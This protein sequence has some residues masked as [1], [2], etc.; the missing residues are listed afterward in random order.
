MKALD[1]F[2]QKN[3]LY[4][5]LLFLL[6]AALALVP[7]ALGQAYF[8]TVSGEVSDTTGAMVAGA[9]VVLTDQRK[10]FHFETT[11]D[12]NG[13]YLFRTVPPGVYSVSAESS[14][15]NRIVQQ[16]FTVD[17]NQNATVNLTMRVAGTEQ[18]VEV[19]AEALTIQTEDAETGQVVNRRFINDLPLIGRDVR[20]LTSLAPG[21]TEMDDQCPEP[22]LGTNFVS[23]GSRGAQA[24]ILLDGA[25]VTNSEPNGGITSVTY[26]PSPE[27]VEEFK[28]EQTNFSAEYGFSGGSVVNVIGRSGTN[29]FH[30]SVYEFF[31]D[32]S[33][34][35]ND[36]FAN[37]AGNPI[38]PL[39]RSNYGGTIGGPIFKNKT[40][41]FF[42]YDGSRE[43]GLSTASG[44][45]PSDAM[46][47][48]D[49]GEVCAA[50]GGTF[51]G[52]GLCS[53]PAGQ[54]WD[55]YSGTFN[56]TIT[57]STFI[58]F[59][60]L[61]TY[62]S[63]GPATQAP[64]NLIDPVAQK[65]MSYFPEPNFA[66]GGIYQN[67]VGSGSSHSS[68]RQFDIRI[69]HRFSQNDLITG[70]FSYQYT[71]SGTGLDCFK[72]FT[73]PCQGGPGWTNAHA[74]AFNETHTFSPTLLL[75]TTLGFTRGVWHIDSYNPHGV[76]DPLGTLGFPS[77][78]QANGFTGVP[79]IFIDQYSPAG[80]PNIG[81]DPYGNYRLGQDTGQL[82]AV[83]DKVHGQHDI[84]FGFDGRIHQMNY[85]QTNAPVGFFSFNTD[86]TDKCADGLD[87]CGG[88]SMASFMMGQMTQNCAS[89]GCGSYEEIQFRPATTNYQYAFFGQDNWKVTQKLTLN[90][91]LRYDFTLPR[92][93]RF[94]H[95]DWFDPNATSPLNGGSLTYTNPVTGQ[96]VSVALKGGEV[97][98][99]SKER[100]N[101]VTDWHDIQPRFGFAYQFAPKMV[102]RGGFGIYYAQSRSGVTGVVPYGSAGFNRFTNVITVNPANR[103]TPFVNLSNPFP[104]G[105]SQP[106][107]NS[108]GLL[109]DVG[110]GANGPIR[111]PG[112]NQTPYEQSW[113]FGIERE[114]P[115]HIL[116]NAE[117]IGKKGT[118]LPFDNSVER[119]HL[120]PWVENLPI[121]DTSAANPCQAGLSIACLISPVPNPF[122]TLITDPNSTIGSSFS[123]IP[124]YQLLLPYPQ[125]TGVSTEPLLIGNS[126]YHGLQLT[127]EK[128]YSNGL[129]F[130]AS[131][132]WSKSIDNSSQADTNVS[133]LGSFDS[134]QDPNKPWLERS[135]STFDIPY[136][137]QF[138]YSYDLPIG[139][140]RA[141]LGNMPRWA[142]A[143]LG[144][145]K[146]NGIWR[147]SDGRPLAF[148]VADGTLIPTYGG[149]SQTLRPN[150]VG[151]PKRNNGSDWVDNYFAGNDPNVHPNFV[152][153]ADYTLGDAP[154]TI[155]SLRSPSHFT[156]DLSIGKQFRIREEMNFE[157]RIEAQNAFNHPV[158]GTPDTSVDDGNFGAIT[159]TSVG[160]RQVQ[161]GFK[162]NF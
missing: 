84:K 155:G 15:F 4:S 12:T 87:A 137:F 162:F 94:N 129:Q 31:R 33:L 134:L 124:Y 138:S 48:G 83:L 72:N 118:H 51:D 98:A 92:T 76:T 108:L 102:V 156:T 63:P 159:S 120:G 88:D 107:G 123:T 8:G 40:F 74:I 61:A 11:S 24:D 38:P 50:Q 130:L 37:R 158:F 26:L 113:S 150:I 104:F 142:D 67:W 151:T 20:S 100:T 9:K 146:T 47:A 80:Y 85:I 148:T 115:S 2:V 125:F 90:L 96:P 71:P 1:S 152:R 136:V 153:P 65:M 116:I 16:N 126:I 75:T 56:G 36:W 30:G 160:P 139:H 42:D 68:N 70:K 23:N 110:F 119:D 19:S 28:V 5:F 29:N 133:W 22:C 62:Q 39:R 117:Y 17:V 32:G 106:A 105:L 3:S 35:A 154:R 79:A 18:K 140:G 122:Q 141:F 14:G 147:I 41:F 53:V 93:D 45:V 54:I 99:S 127:G 52:S 34:D 161:L 111:T 86:A 44:A 73:D 13:H 21:V 103:A 157:F 81:T 49:F 97:F 7:F 114:L 145:W 69:D 60:N 89:N 6:I 27:A 135:L 143:I 46:R 77:Y 66:S 91:G 144:G 101:Y 55:P 64:G 59:N 149:G 112:A 109:N 82:A 25:S 131:F 78:L 58:P 43:T 95:Q 128:K 10:G 57:R 121:G 132:T